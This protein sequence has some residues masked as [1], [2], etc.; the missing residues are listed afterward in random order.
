MPVEMYLTT[1][2]L[3]YMLSKFWI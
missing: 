2:V 1:V 3:Y